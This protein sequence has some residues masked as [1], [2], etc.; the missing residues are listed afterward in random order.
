MRPAL[1]LVAALLAAGC[2]TPGS[3]S[4]GEGP[5][6]TSPVVEA[7]WWPVGSWWEVQLE[8]AGQPA[9]GA[10]LV[11]FWNDS[12]TSHFWLGVK[13]RKVA[14]DHALHDTNPL[15][16]RIHWGL[17]TPHEKGIHA[18]GMYTFPTEPG[19]SFGGLAF[20]RT[21]DITVEAGDEPGALH[22]RGRSTEG[23]TIAYDYD[24]ALQWFSF[25]EVKDRNGA[26]VL[27][28]RVIDHGTTGES[29]PYYFL[30]GR[31]YYLG[32][33]GAGTHEES[34]EVKAEDIPHKSLAVEI[35]GRTSGPLRLD[36]LSPSGEIKHSETLPV[37]GQLHNVIE[38]P[39]PQQGKWTL[40]YVGAGAF[41][42]TIEAVGI[43]EYT[44]TL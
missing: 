8:Q 26:P 2:A 17:L 6:A 29:G 24:P 10:R 39:S 25:V 11:H 4:E 22:F 31:D 43:L 36:F 34:F 13:D 42:G 37:G 9:Q 5:A 27:V 44:K 41:D 19:D 15:L 16:G 12:A 14:L 1:L 38:I 35:K 23:D 3:D 21:W 32:P 40:R 30:R 28:A 18:Q 20:G 7:P 33:A